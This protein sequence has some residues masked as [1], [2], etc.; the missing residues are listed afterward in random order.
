MGAVIAALLLASTTN[1]FPIGSYK[2]DISGV[3]KEGKSVM[4][5]YFNL[6]YL[7]MS[8]GFKFT[9]AGGEQRGYWRQEGGKYILV[10][11]GFFAVPSVEPEEVLRKKVPKNHLEGLVLE[12]GP[13]G[14]L[15][16]KQ[17]GQDWGPVI[18]RPLPRRSISELVKLSSTYDYVFGTEKMGAGEEAHN[19]LIDRVNS[20]WSD[21]LMFINDPNQSWD[22]R[23]WA[24]INLGSLKDSKGIEEAARMIPAVKDPEGKKREASLRRILS[25]PAAKR[26]TDQTADLLI[27]FQSQALLQPA[28]VAPALGRLKREKDTDLL[29]GWLDS[30]REYDKA[31]SLQALTQLSASKALPKA[32][33]L[34]NDPKVSVQLAAH[35]LIARTTPD[36]IERKAS[37]RSIAKW[38]K[39]GDFMTPSY[40][41]D[42]LVNSR[43]P[44]AFPYLVALLSSDA[45]SILRSNVADE[46]GELGDLRAVPALLEARQRQ[47]A[48]MDDWPG[49][50]RAIRSASEALVK[51]GRIK[52]EQ[53]GM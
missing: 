51:L 38:T 22:H 1:Q 25:R 24:A 28:D 23:S 8:P 46:L 40:A 44:E 2:P 31:Y 35:A 16:L 15:I 45:S 26:P 17:W 6:H 30:A 7:V 12:K 13:K 43:A 49:E 47:A 34:S 39:G 11:D 29:I 53:A 5:A 50:A 9:L 4:G 32:R 52:R 10:F 27:K 37:V 36:E 3:S 18:Y 41:V 33:Q 48:D 19:A 20:D 21:L 14:T 42:A